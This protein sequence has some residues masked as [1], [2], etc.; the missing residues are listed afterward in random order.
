MFLQYGAVISTI[1]VEFVV[2]T[3]IAN[4]HATI[5]GRQARTLLESV[6]LRWFY[7]GMVLY[8]LTCLQCSLQVTLTFQA[9]IHFTDWVVGHAHLVMFGVFAF[10][11][12]GIMTYLFPRLLGQHWYS[13]KLIE[14]HYWLTVSGMVVMFF[15]LTFAGVFQ[16][17]SWAAM[18]IWENSIQLSLV[19]WWIRLGAGLAII[20][21][22]VLFVVNLV[23]TYRLAGK[24]DETPALAATA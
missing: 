7:T 4:F 6:P 15:D 2:L 3:V 12:F 17:F 9:V 24:P 14:W 22:Q 16:G 11:I 19:F 21:G 23:R 5:W 8:A 20:V 13:A 1:A 10:W 18:E